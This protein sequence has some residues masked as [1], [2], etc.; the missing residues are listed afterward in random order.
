MSKQWEDMNANEKA[1]SLREDLSRV[2]IAIDGLPRRADGFGVLAERNDKRLAAM[3]DD[4]NVALKALRESV[5]SP[6][7]ALKK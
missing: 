6:V 1:N 4:T 7:G 2:A 3:I 5:K